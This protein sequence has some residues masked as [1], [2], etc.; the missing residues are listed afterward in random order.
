MRLSTSSAA[1]LG[2]LWITF[3]LSIVGAVATAG[4]EY[5]AGEH[6]HLIAR[7]QLPDLSNISTC[8]VIEL[9][10]TGYRAGVRLTNTTC[11]CAS[12]GLGQ[13]VGPCLIANCTMQDSLDVAKL[14]QTQCNHESDT[15]KI[16]AILITVYVTAVIAIVLRLLAKNMAKT[17]SLDDALIIAAIVIAIALYLQFLS[18]LGFGKHLYDLKPGGLLQILRPVRISHSYSSHLPNP[19]AVYAAE[20]VYVFF[21]IAA[22]T[23]IGFLIVGQVVIGFLTIFSCH[24]IEL[25]WNKDIHTGACLD[26]NQLAYANSA[27]AIIQD[28]LILALPIAMLPGLQMNRNKK[29]SVAMVFLLGSVGFVSTII[30]LQ[31]LAVFGNSIDPTWDYAPVVWWTT[32]EL[33]VVVV[34]ACA[35]MI[36]NLVEKKFPG[37]ALF[38]R[39]TTPKPSKGS[40][41][42]SNASVDKPAKAAGRYQKFGRSNSPPQFSDNYVRDYIT[43]PKGPPVPPKDDL[44]PSRRYRDMYAYGG[45]KPKV[46][47][48]SS[49]SSAVRP[50]ATLGLVALSLVAS[51][52]GHGDG[53]LQRY[54]ALETCP[55]LKI[56]NGVNFTTRAY[57]MRQANLALPNPCPFAAFGSVI[58][59][60]TTGG[61][62]ELVCTGAN[63]NAGTGNPTLHGEMAAIDNCSAI[64]V[65]PQGPYRMTP[66]QALAAFANLTIYT[67]AESCPMC[68]SAV[69]W[70][71]FREYVFGTSI[72]TLTEEGWGQ[73]QITSRDVFRQSSGLPRRTRLLGPVLTN[74]TDPFFSWQF[75]AG[76]PC[77]QGCSR[78][79]S[80]GG[81]VPA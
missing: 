44:P 50:L 48:P 26:V 2:L 1:S 59:N 32:I 30:R 24:P 47:E 77:P 43:S 41:P 29:V 52:V 57:W 9:P 68:A 73:I 70:A 40:S 67:N 54:M 45:S 8:G 65:D 37:F 15:G 46:L 6:V 58:V 62:G 78:G 11:S 35:P 75:N 72:E 22:Y 33:G 56:V 25:F 20:I 38:A 3:A 64:F 31:V 21:R 74:E 27:L 4:E 53:D 66:A 69:R 79:G 18:S 34:C 16:L 61:L 49:P 51:V 42:S 12:T 80:A 17:W 28:L 60:H 81:C 55:P 76:A 5:F 19:F 10:R 13:L 36:R 71:G 39:W 7:Q 63:N 14:Q 23:L